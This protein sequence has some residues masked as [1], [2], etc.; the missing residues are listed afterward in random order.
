METE[1]PVTRSG[2]GIMRIITG[3]FKAKR[4]AKIRIDIRPTS[5]K[6]RES[7]FNVLGDDVKGS[8]WLDL[9]AGSGV[10][11]MEALSRGAEL[12]IF[13]DRDRNSRDLIRENLKRCGA[14]KGFELSGIDAFAL[15][16]DPSKLYNKKTADYIFLDPPYGFGRYRKL[17]SKAIT[18]PL[19][20]ELNTL[21]MIEIF[22]KTKVDFIPPELE[23]NRK[24]TCGD[25]HLLILKSV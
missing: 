13:N 23:L 14:S 7:L 22:R 9:F 3:L 12:V 6:L 24:I 25:S 19:F 21:I 5:E 16:R 2:I 10:V 11:G 4:L 17:L 20:D 18:S 15:I 8:I 1:I